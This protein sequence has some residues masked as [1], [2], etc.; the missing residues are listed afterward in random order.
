MPRYSITLALRAA[1][2]AM[3]L[4]SSG[5]LAE[6][7]TPELLWKL[8]RLEGGVVSPDGRNVAYAVR[9]YDLAENKGTSAVYLVSSEGGNP[10]ALAEGLSS[11]SDLQWARTALGTRLYLVTKR[12]EPDGG[13][14]DGGGDTAGGDDGRSRTRAGTSRGRRGSKERRQRFR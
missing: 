14:G 6:R 7:M 4:L 13:N 1:L 8:G 3:M 9:R 12:P 2:P 11:A 10:R 5:L